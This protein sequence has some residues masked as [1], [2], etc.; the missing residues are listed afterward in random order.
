[1]ENLLFDI[2]VRHEIIFAPMRYY[3]ENWLKNALIKIIQPDQ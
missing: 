3:I 1:M 2:K